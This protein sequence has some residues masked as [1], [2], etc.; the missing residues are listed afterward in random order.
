M[1]VD[2]LTWHVDNLPEATPVLGCRSIEQYTK[3][4]KKGL[5]DPLKEY[6]FLYPPTH[7]RNMGYR[8]IDLVHITIYTK[9]S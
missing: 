2:F 7:N 8:F 5:V 9:R 6:N 1:G 3:K 4:F